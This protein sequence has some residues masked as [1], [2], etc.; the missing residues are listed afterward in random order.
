MLAGGLVTLVWHLLSDPF[1]LE[2]VAGY[3]SSLAA[4]LAV[5][6]LTRHAPDEQIKAIFFE[7]IDPEDYHRRFGDRQAD[8]Q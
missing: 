7:D 8:R 6:L 2:A 5:S 4:T 1:L 3:L